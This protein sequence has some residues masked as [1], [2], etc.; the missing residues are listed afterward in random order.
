MTDRTASTSARGSPTTSAADSSGIREL[1]VAPR[2]STHPLV[3]ESVRE[4]GTRSASPD[5]AGGQR[6][7]GGRPRSGH[8]QPD[9]SLNTSAPSRP[10]LRIERRLDDILTSRTRSRAK[11]WTAWHRRSRSRTPSDIP[12][13]RRPITRSSGASTIGSPASR[14]AGGTA[15]EYFQEADRARPASLRSHT[16]RWRM[17]TT[18]SG[19]YSPD[20]TAPRVQRRAASRPNGRWKSRTRSPPRHTELALAKF[21][22]EWDWEGSEREFRRSLTLDPANPLTHIYY[23]WLLV[24]LGRDGC[25]AS[26]EAQAGHALAPSSRLVRCG[27]AQTLYLAAAVRRSHRAVRRVPAVRSRLRLRAAPARPVLPRE[28]QSPRRDR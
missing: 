26:A 10:A 20:E 7:A 19:L 21:G 15:I 4:I 11:S 18:S 17:P 16:W 22:G 3:G 1:R 25:G 28:P 9:R 6:S 8:R 14:G 13:T 12:R 5:G 23:S 24:L 2:T 27:Q